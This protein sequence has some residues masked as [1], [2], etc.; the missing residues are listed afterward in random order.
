MPRAVLILIAL[1]ATA[2]A[3]TID[4][5]APVAKVDGKR[6]TVSKGKRAGI[7]VGAHGQL[8]AAPAGKSA[9]SLDVQLA[10]ATVVAVTDDTATISLEAI[11][12]P[13]EVGAYF[14]YKLTVPPAL[15]GSALFRITALGVELRGQSADTPI[16]T[17][18]QMLADPSRAPRA[19]D[20]MI[21]DVRDIKESITSTLTTPFTEGKYRGKTAAQV[22]D[23]LDRA[24]VEEFLVFV[25][26]FPGKYIAHRW[27]LP[28]VLF[29]WILNGTPSGE[30]ERKQ[31][32]AAGL[33][34]A[35]KDATT[36]GKLVEARAGWQQVLAQIPDD[37]DAVKALAEL[38]HVLLLQRVIASDPDDTASTYKLANELLAIGAYNLIADPLAALAKRKFDPYKIDQLRGSLLLRQ[39][40]YLDAEKLYAALAPKHPELADSLVLARARAAIARDPK[41]AAGYLALADRELSHKWWDSAVYFYHAALDAP[42]ATPAQRD[43]AR[44]GQQQVASQREIDKLLDWAR[45]S[46]ARHDLKNARERLE[47]AHLADKPLADALADLAEKARQAAEPELALE[48]FRRRVQATP[49][50]QTAHTALAYALLGDER[51]D[52]ADAEAKAAIALPGDPSYAYLIR[53]YAARGDIAAVE[54]YAEKALAADAKYAWPHLQLVRAA[55]AR[56]DWEAAVARAKKAWELRRDENDMRVALAAANLGQ[57]AAEALKGDPGSGRERLRLVRALAELGLAKLAS[58]EAKKLPA[59]LRGDGFWAIATSADSRVRIAERVAAARNAQPKTETRKRRLAELEAT[60][61]VRAQPGDDATRFK[62]ARMLISGE[63]FDRALATLQPITTKSGVDALIADARLGLDVD[64]Q[65]K[66]TEQALVRQDF[67]G[68]LALAEAAQQLHDRIGTN[69]GRVVARERR[70]RALGGLHRIPEGI[71]AL[72]DA[73]KLAVALGDPDLTSIVE[74]NL[75]QMSSTVGTSEPLRKA[76]ESHLIAC[77]AQDD[78]RQCYFVLVQLARVEENDGRLGL[79]L[80]EARKSWTIAERIGHAELARDA[81]FLMADLELGANHLADA[82][83]LAKALLADSRAASDVNNEQL[84]LMVLGAVAMMRADAKV[85]HA[86]FQEVYELG[87]RTGEASWRALARRFDG[88]AALEAEHEPARAIVA[89]EQSA[90]IYRPLGDLQ[91]LEL[92]LFELVDARLQTNQLADA[93]KSAVEAH[94]IADKLQRASDVAR[95][96]VLLANVAIAEKRGDEAATQAKA[97]LALAKGADSDDLLWAI[98]YANARAA[99]LQGRDATDAY[100]KALDAIGRMLQAAGEDRGGFLATGHVRE[101]YTAAIANLMKQG[102]TARAMEVLELSRD[103]TLKQQF[104]ATKVKPKDPAL[105]SK[106]E[107]ADQARAHVIGLQKQLQQATNPAQQKALGEQIA[108]S[109]QELN[110]V[111]LDLK[112]SHRQL[113]Q[114]LAMDPQNLVGR[115]ADLPKGSVL[116]EYFVAEDALYAFVVSAALAQPAVVKVPVTGAELAKTVSKWRAQIVKQKADDLGAKLGDWLLA[117]L[118]PHLAGATTL[119]VLPFGPLYYV[120]FDALVID[121]HYAIEDYRFAMQTASTLEHVL[122]PARAHGSGTLLAISNPDG[123]LPGAQA[124]VTR[125][126]KS[127]VPDA[128]VLVRKDATLDRFRELAGSYRFLHL[129]THGIL[130]A[131]PRKTYLKLSDGPL[132]VESIVQLQG[133]DQ[134]NELVVLS[135][136]DTAM[137]EGKS[138]GDELVSVASGF[139]MAGAPSLI[140]S[141]WAVSDESTAEL[142]TNFYKGLEHSDRLDALRAAKLALLHGKSFTTPWH[143]AAFQLY[144]DFR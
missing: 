71:A 43:A 92:V 6:A 105:R 108:K 21:A 51:L 5:S 111:V 79:A 24:Q 1:C 99:E 119:I 118:K 131:D 53:S 75:A 133:L 124:E 62:L 57:R 83:Q 12:E 40:K 103:A 87:V 96:T 72:E 13:V 112:V 36:A 77:E 25:E 67:A 37:K 109:R 136:C 8:F 113:F 47:Q 68:A 86:R 126:V 48:L 127:A 41:S 100:D 85:A 78:E 30:R 17:V 80:E 3:E 52:E 63:E 34:R 95:A 31:R 138:T 46:I 116:V 140:A 61:A 123:S 84:S 122:R 38:D 20:E 76:L 49:N 70:G 27:R 56:G 93:R 14:F 11:A 114:A 102:K 26:G 66:A 144:G 130:D 55:A 59:D 91:A 134:T 22:I 101:L 60:A 44:K 141:L 58:D 45:D 69:Y 120:P 65:D 42:K 98:W 88:N 143:W 28:E 15:A 23:G 19:I 139:S 117:P 82:E 39:E 4:A 128:R 129:A 10:R 29:T 33:V 97:A 125:I 110:Q 104:D 16:V 107:K 81:R 64:E 89:L 73:R 115:R 50:D 135:A 74:Q 94:A 106:L 137:E 9:I 142:M 32:A 132:T 7:A 18:E 2:S 54:Q 121:G 35:A 90:E